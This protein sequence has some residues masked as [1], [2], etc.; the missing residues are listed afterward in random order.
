MAN[1]LIGEGHFDD[2]GKPSGTATPVA[3]AP[4]GKGRRK[5]LS[6]KAKSIKEKLA[7]ADGIV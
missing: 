1:V 3:E 4:T 7:V 6:K 2:S 5:G